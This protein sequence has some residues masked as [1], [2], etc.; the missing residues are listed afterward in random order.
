MLQDQDTAY[1][2]LKNDYEKLKKFLQEM[3]IREIQLRSREKEADSKLEEVEMLKKEL[4]RIIETRIK[5]ECESVKRFYRK[6]FAVMLLL[7]AFS[8]SIGIICDAYDLSMN[9]QMNT[10]PVS[11]NT[12]QTYRLD[13]GEDFLWSKFLSGFPYYDL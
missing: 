3:T 1:K 10:K 12:I 4:N 13:G 8:V 6:C 11:I 2:K 5:H 9:L 7:L